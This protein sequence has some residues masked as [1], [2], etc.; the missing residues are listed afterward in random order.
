MQSRLRIGMVQSFFS[1]VWQIGYIC[2]ASKWLSLLNISDEFPELRTH[3]LATQRH[4]K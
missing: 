1:A 2:K 3:A 4:N